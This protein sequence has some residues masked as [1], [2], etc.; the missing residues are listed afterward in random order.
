MKGFSGQLIG[1]LILKP[2][3]GNE[4]NLVFRKFNTEKNLGRLGKEENGSKT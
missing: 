3:N 2:E 1:N 4:K